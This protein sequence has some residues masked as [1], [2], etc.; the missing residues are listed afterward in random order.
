V[1]GLY[2]AILHTQW[3]TAPPRDLAAAL[4]PYGTAMIEST[5]VVCHGRGVLRVAG[6]LFDA[7]CLGL[8]HFLQRRT[9]PSMK[10][11]VIENDRFLSKDHFIIKRKKRVIMKI[12][13]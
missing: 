13:A 11:V 8:P 6:Y 4:H 12:R 3:V 2:Y 1:R 7:L 10:I 9:L 5:A